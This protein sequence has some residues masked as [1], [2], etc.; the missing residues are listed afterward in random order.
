MI[1]SMMAMISD[2]WRRMAEASAKRGSSRQVGTTQGPADRIDVPGGLEAREEEPAAVGGTVRVHQR[3]LVAL[4]RLGARDLAQGHLQAEV[5]AQDVGARPQ[6]RDLD[7]AAAARGPLLE[8]RG[9]DPREGREPG[10][11]VADATA[12]VERRALVVGHLHREPGTGPEGPDV[13][14][15]TVPLVAAQPVAADAAVHE[16]RVAFDRGPRLESEPVEGVRAEVADEDVGGGEQLFE[17][18]PTAGLPEV[19]H[20]AALAPVVE[21]ERRVRHVAV[22]AQ[23]PEHLSHRITARCF[24]L[25]H[26]GAPV[27]QE[28]RRR[29]S[30]D[31]DAHL[32]D[33]QV[34]ERREP[35]RRVGAHPPTR[36]RWGTT[37]SLSRSFTTFPV[38]LIGSS[39]TSSTARGTL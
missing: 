35:R 13:V 25:D 33:P 16:T 1:S 19:E 36:E 17:T 3:C 26:V 12:G 28:G 38:A 15:G 27:G 18:L 4:S 8:H 34:G 10:D 14:G 9:E 23:R 11:V 6:Q 5:P 37:R 24:D 21:R 22:D 2:R 29:R 31:P 7:D 32:H 30:G 39:S 20:H